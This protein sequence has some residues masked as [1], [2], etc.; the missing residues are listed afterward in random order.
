[1]IYRQTESTVKI[2]K[3]FLA[4]Q[5]LPESYGSEGLSTLDST[6]SELIKTSTAFLLIPV[7]INLCSEPIEFDSWEG[8]SVW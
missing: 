5:G 6:D 4:D 2:L 3:V 7:K 8:I 1:M